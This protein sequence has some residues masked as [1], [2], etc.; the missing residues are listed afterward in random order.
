MS[1]S[2]S[3]PCQ[4]VLSLFVGIPRA[5]GYTEILYPRLER[6]PK[7]AEGRELTE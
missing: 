7:V 4:S 2:V 6:T 1:L 3:F 5:L